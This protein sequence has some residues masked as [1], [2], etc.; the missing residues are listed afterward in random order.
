MFIVHLII[1]SIPHI[2]YILTAECS[3]HNELE[4]TYN[5]AVMASFEALQQQLLGGTAP[6]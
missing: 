6:S 4:M 2:I 3:V 1:P 5:E